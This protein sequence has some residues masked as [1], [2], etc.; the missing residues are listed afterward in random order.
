M[1]TRTFV[2]QA[3]LATLFLPFFVIQTASAALTDA[4]R[5]LIKASISSS[6]YFDDHFEA[7]VWLTDMS[8]R[9]KSRIRD[10]HERIQLLNIVHAEAN[11]A[12]LEPELVLAIIE[13]E[14]SF[15][16]WAISK[17]GARGLMQ[18]MP[19]WVKELGNPSDNLFHLST[20]IRLGCA[21]LRH[22]LDIEKGNL[23]KALARYNGSK[24]SDRYPSKV[25]AALQNNWYSP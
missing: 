8:L 7:Q 21:V 10:K 15:N 17:V 2:Q 19:F 4:E 12:G 22:Y 5:H 20:N 25:L 24:G 13:V 11:R 23:V 18:V 6:H 16:R 14:S 1:I 9:L 3:F